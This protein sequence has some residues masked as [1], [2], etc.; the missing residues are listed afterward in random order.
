MNKNDTR[1]L[2]LLQ[3]LEKD[4]AGKI[5]ARKTRNKNNY[6]FKHLSGPES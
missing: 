5:R 2:D 1:S 4:K 3:L 6:F